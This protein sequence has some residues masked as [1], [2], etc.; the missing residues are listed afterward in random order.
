MARGL[1]LSFQTKLPLPRIRLFCCKSSIDYKEAFSRRM[2]MSGLKPHHPIAIGVSGGADSMALCILTA[3]WKRDGSDAA[4][5]KTGGFVDGL[6]AIV[7]DHG[8]RSESKEEAYIVSHRVSE[9]GIR[10]EIAS[11]SWSHGKPK[12]GH[13]QEDA[14]DIRYQKLQNVCIQHQIGVLLIAHHA[15]DQ[16]ELFI[17]RLSR[18]SGVLGLAGMAFV[19]Q[20]FF[21]SSHM[22]GIDSKNGGILLVRPLLDFSKEDMYKVCQAGGHDWV[23]DPTN[24]SPVYARNRIRLSLKEFSSY[25]FKCE[26]QALVSACQ[27][28][29]AYV[30]QICSNLLNQ[31]VTLN[32][33]GYAIIDLE[34]LNPSK[35]M[36]MCLAK[37]VALIL[38]F[39]SQRHRPVR[40]STSKLLLD[41]LRRSP[42]KTSLTA[43]GCYLC[44]APGSRGTKVVVCCSVDCPLPSKMEFTRIDSDGEQRQYVPC[45]L[46]AIIAEAKSCSDRFS[47]DASEVYFL[48]STSES[49][50]T[51]AKSLN[52][53]SE[54]TYTNIL[55]LQKEELKHFKT[56]IKDG[57]DYES[58]NEVQSLIASSREPLQPGQTC[59]FINR[60]LVKWEP[61]TTDLEKPFCEVD[62]RRASRD[63]CS[64]FCKVDDNM[65]AEVRTMIEADW[66]YLA[67]LSKC[68]SLDDLDKQI[69]YEMGPKTEEKNVY[70]DYLRFSA[71]RSLMTLKSIP[72]AARRSLPVLVDHHGQLLSIPSIGFGICHCLKVSCIFMPRVP[73]G[74]G[75]SSFM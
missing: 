4:A 61:G 30:D 68:L 29:R 56:K 7:V 25:A 28:T 15:D 64:S 60:F 58:K 10:C 12:Q 49:V 59:F 32:H 73:L 39:V 71:Q 63:H 19:S 43:A 27:K 3:A 9:M 31:A 6:L 2:A 55:S 74:G 35:L 62:F 41:Y 54:S 22:Y 67:K 34:I 65:D 51:E 37:F 24:Q 47:P 21:S 1:L 75:Y 42:C 66:L 33:H 52:I 72:V 23:E 5:G 46:E 11:C 36:D 17:L 44:P 26:L 48:E 13:L 14:R 53:I 45:E 40:G 18:N 69:L 20:M 50:L 8:L 57:A 16:A 38:Q 70:L